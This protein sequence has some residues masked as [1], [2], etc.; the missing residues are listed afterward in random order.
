MI[1]L[2]WNGDPAYLDCPWCGTADL[3]PWGVCLQSFT[4]AT[5]HEMQLTDGQLYSA[6]RSGP[7]GEA[8]VLVHFKC[9]QCGTLWELRITGGQ[10]GTGLVLTR[11]ER[12]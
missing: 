12:R 2:E 8:L 1:S 7:K 10:R 11:W 4:G 6:P 5:M 3:Q 9:L